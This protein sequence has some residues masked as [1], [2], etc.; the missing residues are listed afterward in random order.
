LFRPYTLKL[1]IQAKKEFFI[2]DAQAPKGRLMTKE[3][4]I[5]DALHLL[6]F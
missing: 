2:S 1:P 3:N 6:D 5:R 4:E